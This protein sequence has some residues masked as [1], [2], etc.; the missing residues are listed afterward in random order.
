MA[1]KPLYQR[2]SAQERRLDSRQVLT[3]LLQILDESFDR[4]EAAA[5]VLL[6]LNSPTDIADRYLQIFGDTL[7]HDWRT[8]RSYDWNRTRIEEAIERASQKGTR[9][10]QTDVIREFGG[11]VLTVLDMAS[12]L[13]ILGRQGRLGSA[14]CVII[15]PDFYHDGSYLHDIDIHIDT[16]EFYEEYEKQRPAGQLWWY[17]INHPIEGIA[18]IVY[19]TSIADWHGADNVYEGVLGRTLI[20]YL[21]IT[22]GSHPGFDCLVGEVDWQYLT[23][24][25]EGTLGSALPNTELSINE[26]LGVDGG[27]QTLEGIVDW[28]YLTNAYEGTLGRATLN[29]D[30]SINEGLGIYGDF[31]VCEVIETD[32]GILGATV[33]TTSLIPVNYPI[34][35]GTEIMS[36]EMAGI[37]TGFDVT[38]ELEGN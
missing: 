11:D 28:Q 16:P 10:A 1:R 18:E 36:A 13:F 31:G 22:H 27:F 37:H 34:T 8:D 14:D 9:Q 3:R 33:F 15:G 2:I 26:A 23:N 38:D 17:R 20:N 7:D 12:T 32:I 19:T 25:F 29:A 24:T 5:D 35:A 21:P 6:T 30:L 4:S